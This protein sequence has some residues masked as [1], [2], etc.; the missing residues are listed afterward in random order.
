MDLQAWTRKS[1][2]GSVGV[3]EERKSGKDTG[4]EMKRGGGGGGGVHEEGEFR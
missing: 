4:V 3:L 2:D 1:T